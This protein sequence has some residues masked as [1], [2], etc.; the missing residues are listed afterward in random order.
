MKT[1]GRILI[2]LV[3]ALIVVGALVVLVGN[4]GTSQ[5]SGF[6]GQ[7]L[8]TP[9]SGQFQPGQFGDRGGEHEGGASNLTTLIKNAGIF[10]GLS[11]AIATVST[12]ATRLRRKAQLAA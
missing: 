10:A 11:L 12:L 6:N 1:L 4:N 5:A 8:G 3:A 7:G 2:I 9:P